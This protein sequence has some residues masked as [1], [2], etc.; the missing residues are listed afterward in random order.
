LG[1]FKSFIKKTM[2]DSSEDLSSESAWIPYS[3]RP[4]WSDVQPIAQDDGPVPVV[5]IAYS[6]KC[7]HF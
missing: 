3:D 2:S 1:V 4:E 5:R 7:N 6:N